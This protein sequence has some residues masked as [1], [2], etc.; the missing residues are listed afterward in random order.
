MQQQRG[1]RTSCLMK[2]RTKG[3]KLTNLQQCIKSCHVHQMSL[4]IAQLLVHLPG[5]AHQGVVCGQR[6]KLRNGSVKPPWQ[7]TLNS[8]LNSPEVAAYAHK[9]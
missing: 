2:L 1:T 6:W 7:K 3:Q 4:V 9:Q 8:F 5:L